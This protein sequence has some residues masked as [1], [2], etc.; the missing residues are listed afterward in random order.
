MPNMPNR[1]RAGRSSR[2]IRIDDAD[3]EALGEAA[4]ELDLDR[5]WIIRR[6]IAWYLGRADA[7]PKPRDTA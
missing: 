5:G 4:E 7:P 2:G 1:P 3:W 6:L